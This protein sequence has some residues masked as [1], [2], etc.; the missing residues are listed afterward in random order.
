MECNATEIWCDSGYYNDNQCWYGNY[1][2]QQVNEWDGC[3]GVCHMPCNWDTQEYCDMGM[4]SNGCW[5]PRCLPH[6][7]QLGHPGI[8][9]HGNG[10]Q[11]MLAGQ[12]LH[13]FYGGW[14]SCFDRFWQQRLHRLWLYL[15]R[16]LHQ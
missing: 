4:D 1:C 8:L 6:A 5:L 7:L 15:L 9:R 3:P 14:M 2:L 12:L 16:T 10:Q 13:G 11:R